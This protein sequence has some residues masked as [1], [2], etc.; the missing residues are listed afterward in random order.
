MEEDEDEGQGYGEGQDGQ[1][2][3]THGGRAGGDVACG[4]G[5]DQVGHVGLEGCMA[6]ATCHWHRL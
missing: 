5:E 4:L 3:R 1:E 2:G 6:A